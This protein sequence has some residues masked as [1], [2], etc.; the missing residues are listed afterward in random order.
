MKLLIIILLLLG[1]ASC[2]VT[3]Y[4]YNICQERWNLCVRTVRDNWACT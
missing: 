4:C 1:K 3:Q 2:Q